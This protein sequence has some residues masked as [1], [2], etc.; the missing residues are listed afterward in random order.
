[1]NKN[2]NNG[3]R[4]TDANDPYARQYEQQLREFSRI[5]GEDHSGGGDLS[6][7]SI[8]ETFAGQDNYYNNYNL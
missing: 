4:N 7:H 1:M 3:G 5:A 2:I 6:M 8:D